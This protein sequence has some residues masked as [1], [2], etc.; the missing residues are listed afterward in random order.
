V[1]VGTNVQ[2]G[3]HVVVLPNTVVSHDA[4]IGDFTCIAGAAC[5]SGGVTMGD[6]CYAGANASVRERVR[7]GRHALIGMGSAVLHDVPPRTV[8]V[9]RRHERFDGRIEPGTSKAQAGKR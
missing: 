1:T 4:R 8:V 7:I 3:H 6:S 5:I 2:I 9:G